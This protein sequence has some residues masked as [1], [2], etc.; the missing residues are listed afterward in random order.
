MSE[1][2]I[3]VFEIA[4]MA[5]VSASAPAPSGGAARSLA[6]EEIA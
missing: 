1:S 2:L 4:E 5:N 6:T 3:G